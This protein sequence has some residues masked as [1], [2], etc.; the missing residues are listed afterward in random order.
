[1]KRTIP[2]LSAD[3]RFLI[4]ALE[5]VGVG[6]IVAYATLSEAVGRNVQREAR[7][8][9]STA[10]RHLLDDK[11]V[12][13]AV[14]G[15]GLK[16]LADQDKIGVADAAMRHIRNTSRTAVKK[17]EAVEDFAALP[18]DSQRRHNAMMSYLKLTQH[19]SR[20]RQ[21][22]KLEAAVQQAQQSLPIAKTLEALR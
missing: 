7:G 10:R 17:L 5:R 14:A 13:E 3:T 22:K 11:A 12:F 2:E 1:M 4:A 21:V 18:A 9:L 6:E 19:L 20:E 8:C 16:R 15:V